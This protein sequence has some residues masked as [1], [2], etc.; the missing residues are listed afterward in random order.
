MT[1][2]L[3]RN[4]FFR[5]DGDSV[6]NRIA[7]GVVAG[8]MIGNGIG[9]HDVY[10]HQKQFTFG[11]CCESGAL[12]TF[13]TATGSASGMLCMAAYPFPFI[14]GLMGTAATAFSRKSD[15]SEWPE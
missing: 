10:K 7:F 14:F 5:F 6:G 8:G 3:L 12:I 15:K 11:N 4:F 13:L 1:R 9:V 2:V